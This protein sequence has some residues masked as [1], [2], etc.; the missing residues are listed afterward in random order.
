MFSVIF[1]NFEV[2]YCAR[3]I[4]KSA[5][6]PFLAALGFWGALAS[7]LPRILPWP[8]L[9]A[10]EANGLGGLPP[11]PG[12]VGWLRGLRRVQK[13]AAAAWAAAAAAAWAKQASAD[14]RDLAHPAEEARRRQT[15]AQWPRPN[16]P[17]ATEEKREGRSWAE[18][19][20]LVVLLGLVAWAAG[21]LLLQ[22]G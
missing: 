5:L 7:K 9:E 4:A 2:S 10:P 8:V 20:A 13:R 12:R 11:K 16:E 17:T 15:V 1:N 22:A 19:L 3:A 21:E 6:A 14:S 18:P